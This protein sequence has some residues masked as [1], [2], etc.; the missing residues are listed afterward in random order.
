MSHSGALPSLSSFLGTGQMSLPVRY[1]VDGS[2]SSMGVELGGFSGTHSGTLR[3]TL[4]YNYT[5]NP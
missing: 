2:I 3:L 4:E 1:S 5:L